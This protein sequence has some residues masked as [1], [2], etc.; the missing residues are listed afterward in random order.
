MATEILKNIQEEV[1]CP[2]CL[3]L[4]SDPLSLDCGH[5]FCQTCI[6]ANS[7]EVSSAEKNSCPVCR[8]TY[9]PGNMRPNRHLANVASK[10]RE[11]KLSPE[12]EEKKDLCAHHGEKLLLFCKEDWMFICWLCERSQEHRDHHTFLIEEVAKECQEKLQANLESLREKQQK[13]EVFE[14]ALREEKTSWKKQIEIEIQCVQKE[15][16]QLRD[17]IDVEELKELQKLRQ[18]DEN[19]FH[20][21]EESE[22]ELVQQKQ[23]L[24]DLILDMEHTLQASMKEMLQNVNGII[25]R[26]ETLTL[27]EPKSF[28][29]EKRKVFQAPNL[30]SIL[31]E[32]NVQ[33]DLKD[34]GNNPAIAISSNG[35]E[36]KLVSYQNTS[37]QKISCNSCN[38]YVLGSQAF[39]SGKYY[40]EVDVSKKQEWVVGK[41]VKR[42]ASEARLRNTISRTIVMA[43]EILKNIQDEVTCPICLELLLEPLSMDC[44]HSFCQTCI[45]ANSQH[46]SQ[47]EKSRCPVCRT[48]YEAGNMRPNRHLAN[49][50]SRL[51]EVK[52]S[53][54]MGEKNDLCAHHGE[55]LLLFC[56]KDWKFICWLCER[57]QEHRGHHTYLIE[58]VAKECQEYLQANLESMRE[59]QQKAEVFETALREEKTSWKKQI[60]TEI[61]SVQKEFKQMRDIIDVEELK[62][63]RKLRK[64][65]ENIFHNLEESEKKLVQQKQLLQDLIIDME[66]TLQASMKEMLQN[67]KDIIKRSETL[68][69]TEPKSFPLGKRKVFQAPDLGRILQELNELKNMQRYWGR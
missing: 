69:L 58:E 55:K 17:I 2:I 50:A 13:A 49:I 10:L 19:I 11:V 59:K 56:K 43:T 53:S 27:I 60:E 57:S 65:N 52:L 22:K 3:E 61:Q 9:E 63:L 7:Q 15:F 47:A 68:T 32:L 31:Q 6:T 46:F 12:I 40:W 66:R 24:Q 28:P 36:V 14:T 67:V 62:E 8:T 37:H 20:N 26:S 18:E 41:T 44:G 64:E 38:N 25:K 5:S 4:L 42:R 45:T 54:E 21:L 1:T 48:T 16:K 39:K 29:L 35:R 51:R 23:L 34:P 33:M 30:G